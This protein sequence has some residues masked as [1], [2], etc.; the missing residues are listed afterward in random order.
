MLTSCFRPL[1]I[2]VTYTA[3]TDDGGVSIRVERVEARDVRLQ[4]I[5]CLGSH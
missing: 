3:E 4:E 5:E 1:T 2:T